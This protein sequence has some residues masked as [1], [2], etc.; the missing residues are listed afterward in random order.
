VND[1]KAVLV[2]TLNDLVK[3]EDRDKD[4]STVEFQFQAAITDLLKV[5]S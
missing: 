5:L 3:V 1:S 2:Q 4:P